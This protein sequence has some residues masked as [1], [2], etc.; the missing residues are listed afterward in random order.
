MLVRV[1]SFSESTIEGR[2][3]VSQSSLKKI[4]VLLCGLASDQQRPWLA[5]RWAATT[6]SPT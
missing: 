2:H 5:A 4:S 1:P 3:V 6:T